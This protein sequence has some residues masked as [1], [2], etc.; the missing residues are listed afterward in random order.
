MKLFIGTDHRG[1]HLKERIKVWLIELGFDIHDVG[2]FVLSPNDDYTDYASAVALNVSKTQYAQGIVFCGSGVGVDIVA[3]KVDG[4][5]SGY[6]A[7]VEEV[8]SARRDDDIH[9]LAVA[10][11]FTDEEKAKHLIQTFLATKYAKIE[12]HERRLKEISKI[13][14]KN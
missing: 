1:Y 7:S 4:V 8:E 2:A 10:A 11:D 5:R 6:A 3:N 14:E 12:R 9:V 13:E